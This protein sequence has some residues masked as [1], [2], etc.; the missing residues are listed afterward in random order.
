M[1]RSRSSEGRLDVVGER[2]SVPVGIGY[3]GVVVVFGAL[4]GAGGAL[5]GLTTVAASVVAGPVVA[6]A[7]AHGTFLVVAHSAPG[8][9]IAVSEVA[10]G[11]LLVA[12]LR[13]QHG[14]GP[15]AVVAAVA[16]AAF[17]VLAA[18]VYDATGSVMTAAVTLSVVAGL[19]AYAIHR[20][21]L[22]RLGLVTDD[23]E[24]EP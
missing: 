18:G 15:T 5:A 2:P 12:G 19:V 14:P 13:H 4:W 11:G 9:T 8:W 7:V 21:E 1:S 23:P 10:L 3:V 17:A 24:G 16:F 6:V 22:V 20:Y